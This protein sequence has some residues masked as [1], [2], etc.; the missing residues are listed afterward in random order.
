MIN[1][2]VIYQQEHQRSMREE[3]PRRSLRDHIAESVPYWI[4]LVALGN[5]TGQD[6]TIGS[7][8]TT[9]SDLLDL[10]SSMLQGL[11]QTTRIGENP[12]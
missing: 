10:N 11:Q 9:T 12:A 1:V 6:V 3:V 4:I 2:E 7:V 5:R 8:H